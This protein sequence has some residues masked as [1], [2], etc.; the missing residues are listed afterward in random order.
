MIRAHDC[1]YQFYANDTQLY[2]QS[3]SDI[4]IQSTLVLLYF[5]LLNLRA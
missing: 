5:F 1:L 3:G 4:S 2:Y